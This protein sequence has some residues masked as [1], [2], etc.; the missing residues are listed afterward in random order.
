MIIGRGHAGWHAKF[1]ER[2]NEVSSSGG[3]LEDYLKIAKDGTP[4]Y[5]AEEANNLEFIHWVFNGPMV[6]VRL[7]P[8]EIQHKSFDCNPTLLGLM[9]ASK[10]VFKSD[11]ITS[12]TF[13]GTEVFM[14]L[15]REKVSGV[16]TGKVF[17]GKVVWD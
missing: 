12:C 2:G 3:T 15:L 10:H 8:N 16:K 14:T 5:D 9:P 13:V 17:A 7:K 11:Q 1:I 4:I 6:T